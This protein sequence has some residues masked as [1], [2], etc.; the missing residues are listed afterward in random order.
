VPPESVGKVAA[1]PSLARPRWTHVA[2]PVQDVD[3]SIAF[4]TGYTPLVVVERFSDDAGRSAWLA[5]E[6]ATDRPFVLVL[7]EFLSDIGEPHPVLRPFA[8]LG[9]EV[10]ERRDVDTLAA[11]AEAGGCLLWPPRQM[12]P[13]VGYICALADPDGNVVEISHDQGVY[14][15]IA[16]R[17]G[18]VT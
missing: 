9:I 18:A 3:R 1:S 12:P 15:A 11:R 7:V 5:E 17:F 16:A 6:G 2:L 14:A 4:Y 8:H 10:P 13:P